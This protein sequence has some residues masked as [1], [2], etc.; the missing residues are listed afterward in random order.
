M[1]GFS[2]H[3]QA[4]LSLLVRA[5]RGSLVKLVREQALEDANWELIAILRL[6]VLLCRNRRDLGHGAISIQ[7]KPNK[8][9]LRL[10]PQWLAENPLSEYLL[11]EEVRQWKAIGHELAVEFS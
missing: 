2:K 9:R 5:H 8:V 10:V 1:P 7:R 4:R 3:D 11:Q 6:A